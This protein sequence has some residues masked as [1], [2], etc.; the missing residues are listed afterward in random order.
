MP[1]MSGFEATR[2]IRDLEYGSPARVPIIAMTAN[3]MQGD[4]ERCVEAGMDGYLPKPV[5]KNDLIEELRKWIPVES[6]ESDMQTPHRDDEDTDGIL[7]MDVIEGLKALGGEGDPGLMEELI[8]LFLADAP[9]RMEEVARGL[10]HADW[11]LLERAAH[12]LKS[13]S[14]NMGARALSKI[15][16][17]IERGAREGKVDGIAELVQSSRKAFSAVQRELE[18]IKG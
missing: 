10:E 6:R 5:R 14:A 18:R 2:A 4:R 17:E 1:V 12:T 16:F 15:C 13:S 8:D 11:E 7:D 3:A 9:A